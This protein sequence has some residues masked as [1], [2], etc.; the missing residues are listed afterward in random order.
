MLLPPPVVTIVGS[1]IFT[2]PE[3]QSFPIIVLRWD[4]LFAKGTVKKVK[5]SMV[6]DSDLVPFF[7]FPIARQFSFADLT[8]FSPLLQGKL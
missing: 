2:G 3:G 4:F 7:H 6:L 1:A 5:Q 8:F